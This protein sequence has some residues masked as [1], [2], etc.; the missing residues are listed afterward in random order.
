[1]PEDKCILDPERD[2]I[3]KAAAIKLEAR[4]DRLE[5]WQRGSKV[6]HEAFYDWQ[7]QQ[8]ARNAALDEKLDNMGKNIQKLL[9]RKEQQDQQPARLWWS[10]IAA[11]ITG[12]VGFVLAQLGMG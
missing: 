1:M 9:D 10:V 6:F 7:R 5:E 11:A 4:I 8:I 3:G 2:C 12:V